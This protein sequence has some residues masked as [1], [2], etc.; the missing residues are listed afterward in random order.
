MHLMNLTSI[1]I[2]QF[3]ASQGLLTDHSSFT[4]PSRLD[5]FH[6]GE[7]AMR[8][9]LKVPPGGNPTVPGLPMRYAMRV[10]QSPLVAVGTLDSDG[11]PWTTVWGGERGFAGP[12]ADGVLG[13]NSSVDMRNDPVFEALFKNAGPDGIVRHDGG[14]GKMMSALAIDLETRDRV[15]LAGVMVAGSATKKDS[16]G[17]GDVQAAMVVTESLGNCPKYLNKKE[18]VTHDPEDAELVSDS[19]PLPHEALDVVHSAD[20]FFLTSTNGPTM[21]TNH[22]GG[23][24]GFMRVIKNEG[25]M[26][27]LVYPECK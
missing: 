19:L 5:G 26:V 22:R 11:R 15:K 3:I 2:V 8:E 10:R 4:M 9:M 7:A 18:I 24:P 17:T 13:F 12:I 21:D 14:E 1:P 6:D 25:D 27:E 23:S 16:Q 20:M